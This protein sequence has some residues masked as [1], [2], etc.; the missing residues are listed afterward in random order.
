MTWC[1]SG[2]IA[3]QVSRHVVNT[4]AGHIRELAARPEGPRISFWLTGQV[5]MTASPEAPTCGLITG[6]PEI[7]PNTAHMVIEAV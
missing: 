1:L 6:R 7:I 2:I 4:L 5:S 3:A